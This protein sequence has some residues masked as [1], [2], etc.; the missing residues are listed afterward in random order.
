MRATI[1]Q[2]QKKNYTWIIVLVLFVLPLVVE[3]FWGEILYDETHDHI[4]SAQ[5]FMYDITNLKVFDNTEEILEYNPKNTSGENDTNTNETVLLEESSNEEYSPTSDIFF[6]EFIHAINSNAFYI[7]LCAF[8]YNFMNIYKIFILYMTIFL[9]NFISSTLSYIFQFPKPYMAFYKIKSVVFFNEWGSPNNQIV[10]LISFGCTFYKTL[11]ANKIC[12]KKLWIKIII[13][14]LLVFYAFID[15]FFLFASGNLTFNQMILSTFLAVAIFLFIFYCFPIDLNKSR[16]FYD[17]MKF[18]AYYWIVINLLI[19]AFQILLSIFITDRRDTTYYDNNLKTQ[20][21]RLPQNDFTNDYCKY[22][23]LFSL[24]I[25]SFCN[26]CSYL[27][28]IVAFLSVKADIRFIYNNNYNSWSEG[29]FENSKIGGG[30]VDGDQSGIVEYNSI[31]KSQ[32]NHNKGGIV[33]L[34]VLLDIIFNAVI[35]VF[36]IWVTHFSDDE[37]VLFIF[38]IIFPMILCI[39]GNLF[40]FKAIYIRMNLAKAPKIKPKNLLY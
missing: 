5:R 34:R 6:T 29:N 17:F 11:V 15:G 40:L 25:G 8:L 36:F 16:Q 26:V 4:E 32:W 3:F 13:I 21:K 18:N 30:I 12:E 20:A 14:I 31:E 22:R 38:L 24:N 1:H 27:M 19:F 39:F 2:V 35:F 10:L 9:A 28:N 7:L 23:E 37:T 33:F